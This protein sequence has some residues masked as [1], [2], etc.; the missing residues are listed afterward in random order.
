MKDDMSA[1]GTALA[2]GK[3]DLVG[4]ASRLVREKPLAAAA[5]VFGVGYVLGGGLFSRFT[6]RLL[7]VGLRVGGIALAREFVGDI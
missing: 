6:G 1:F 4:S 7:G 2:Q 5:V 3:E